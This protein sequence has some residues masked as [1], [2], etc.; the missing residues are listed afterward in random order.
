MS[1]ELPYGALLKIHIH[2]RWTVMADISPYNR[3]YKGLGSYI[4]PR[5]KN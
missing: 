3:P 2:R 1:Y 4:F 5:R